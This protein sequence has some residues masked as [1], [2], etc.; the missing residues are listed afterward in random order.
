MQEENHLS[1]DMKIIIEA[2]KAVI[3]KLGIQNYK[4]LPGNQK[5]RFLF[6]ITN[7]GQ[8]ID[9][10]WSTFPVLID[11]DQ[12]WIKIH[13]VFTFKGKTYSFIDD[14]LKKILLDYITLVNSHLEIGM[15][16]FSNS[17]QYARFENCFCYKYLD[18]K[19]WYA[20]FNGYITNALNSYKAFGFGFVRIIDRTES[21]EIQDLNYLFEICSSRFSGRPPLTKEQIAENLKKKKIEYE[22]I[23]QNCVEVSIDLLNNLQN[24]DLSKYFDMENIER[25]N[26]GRMIYHFD[27][28]L[29]MN[30]AYDNG[31]KFSMAFYQSLIDNLLLLYT[32]GIIFSTLPFSL[33][34]IILENNQVIMFKYSFKGFSEF[35]SNKQITIWEYKLLLWKQLTQFNLLLYSTQ[36]YPEKHLRKIDKISTFHLQDV[37]VDDKKLIIG[38]GGFGTVYSNNYCGIPVAIKFP[39]QRK[40]DIN[41]GNERIKREYMLT[42]SLRHPYILPVYG[43]VHYKGKIGYVMQFC[44][45][46]TLNEIIKEKMQFTHLEKI[47]ILLK[48]A[49][50]LKY[51]HFRNYVHLDIKPHNVFFNKK[52]PML[53]DF[54]L[55]AS[56]SLEKNNGMKLG[57]TIYYSPPEQ[58]R[59]GPPR[60]S[61]DIWAFGMTMYHFL[62][63]QHPFSFLK[64]SRKIEKEAFY[65][66]IKED[67]VRPLI[68]DD[69]AEKYEIEA[70]IMKKC[71]ELNPSYRP[72]IDNICD[73]L[74]TIKNNIILGSE[75]YEMI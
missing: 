54:G 7:L 13:I 52:N 39:S 43:Y 68:S 5:C 64:D 42:K 49:T 27:K 18:K 17:K 50:A 9:E 60:Q 8:S 75:Y 71:W 30:I 38:N 15:L 62:M 35:I 3:T 48:I 32:K 37:K 28:L 12:D 21:I 44:E 25:T 20:A 41:A 67:H 4:F 45:Q 33:I 6:S 56:I 34:K 46:S 40:E 36:A 70:K 65:N 61:S 24:Q 47:E 26:E 69:F 29:S 58:I 14:N 63:E 23:Q 22:D 19:Y 53:G 1:T 2:A 73:K 51:M 16:K 66:L 31:Y 72:D 74:L 10:T 59:N 57:C 55:S 11:I